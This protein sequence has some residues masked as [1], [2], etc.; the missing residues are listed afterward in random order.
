[1]KIKLDKPYAFSPDGVRIERLDAG[2]HDLDEALAGRLIARGIASKVGGRKP[3]D[4][5][6]NKDA[7]A[8]PE[9]KAPAPKRR[10]GAK[11]K[12]D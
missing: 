8:A 7:G 11:K 10:S 3:Q 4:S 12:G 5:P 2:E 9:N 6:E 1:M